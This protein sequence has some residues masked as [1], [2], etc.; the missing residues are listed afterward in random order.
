[1]KIN[2]MEVFISQ[3]YYNKSTVGPDGITHQI[4]TE[5]EYPLYTLHLSKVYFD[6]SKEETVSQ[7]ISDLEAVISKLRQLKKEKEIDWEGK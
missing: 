3:S 2:D 5:T 6:G 4:D 1:M 7:I